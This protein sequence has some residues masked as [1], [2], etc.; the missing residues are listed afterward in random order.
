MPRR[1]ISA[2]R[3]FT[4]VELLVVLVLLGILATIVL[5]SFIGQRAK[6]Q[7]SEAHQMIRNAQVALQTYETDNDTFDAT[8]AALELIEPAIAEAT[9]GFDVSGDATTYKI[10]E[11]SASGT[12]FT[13]ERDGSGTITRSC[14][15]HGH[16]LCKAAPDAAG[17]RW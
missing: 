9:G 11:R 1:R 16:G 13:V 17:N 4:I 12:E 15:V 7:D 14:T 5:P 2:E 6:A 3:G 10:T 8:R